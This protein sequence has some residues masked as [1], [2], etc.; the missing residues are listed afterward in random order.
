MKIVFT[1]LVTSAFALII[2]ASCEKEVDNVSYPK[3]RQKLVI[4]GYI[5]PDNTRNYISVT[6]NLR[7]YG[8]LDLASRYESPGNLTATLSNDTHEISL[9][10]TLLGFVFN[11]SDFPIEEGK[12]YTLKV[13]SDKGLY[14]EASCSVPFKRTFALEIDTFR[15]MNYN[16]YYVEDSYFNLDF[17]Y[18]DIPGEDNY[19][20]FLC[21]Q[22]SYDSKYHESPYVFKIQGPE[23]EYF[24]DKGRDGMR[25]KIALQVVGVPET[26]D[27]SFLKVYLLNTDKAYYDYHKSLGNYTGGEDPFT[28]ASPVYSNITGGL[29]IFAAYTVDSLIVRLK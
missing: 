1:K 6:S 17:Y 19:Y 14:A 3:F 4:S 9:D 16:P 5:S 11:S 13:N 23:K 15:I 26:V 28:E 21:E 22:V 20:M 10:S 2:F 8:D 27:S 12:T 7:I 29:G 25:S 24:N 18:T